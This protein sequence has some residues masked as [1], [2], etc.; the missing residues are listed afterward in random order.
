[1]LE[2]EHMEGHSPMPYLKQ[3]SPKLGQVAQALSCQVWSIS[4]NRVPP[5]F[6]ALSLSLSWEGFFSLY[7]PLLQRTAMASLPFPMHLEECLTDT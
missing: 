3:D 6:W 7:P 2:K 1:M 5:P 4:K